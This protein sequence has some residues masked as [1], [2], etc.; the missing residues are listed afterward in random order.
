M[1]TR[2][3]KWIGSRKS[4]RS[5]DAVTTDARLC[6]KAAIAAHLSIIDRMTPPNTWPMLFACSGIMSS[7]VSCWLS[8]TVFEGR[9]DGRMDGWTSGRMAERRDARILIIRRGGVECAD[10]RA[11]VSFRDRRTIEPIDAMHRRRHVG[12][13]PLASRRIR[14]REPRHLAARVVARHHRIRR[15]APAIVAFVVADRKRRT[16]RRPPR[17]RVVDRDRIQLDD[18]ACRAMARAG[19]R[20][21]HEER[22]VRR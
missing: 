17:R 10:E 15:R 13:R 2:S 5:I 3:P 6:R 22:I 7:D 4:T 1:T 19:H 16:K 9:I 11:A 14:D 20:E 12:E 18:V 8:L 21:P